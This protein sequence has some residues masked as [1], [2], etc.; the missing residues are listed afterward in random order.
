MFQLVLLLHVV[1]CGLI[2]LFVLV[3]QGKG[4]SMGPAFGSGASGTVFG[5]RGAG[6]FLL[7]L[8]TFLA[9]CF[10]VTSIGLTHFSASQSA[11]TKISL[12]EDAPKQSS[13]HSTGH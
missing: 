5:S 7:K 13:T 6:G 10:F 9:L 12:L 11:S 8:T 4:A 3:Q 1:V 2:I